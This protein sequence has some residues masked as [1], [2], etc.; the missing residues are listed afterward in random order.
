MTVL[1]NLIH[2]NAPAE[3][4]WSVLA[5]LDVL[6][7]YDPGI[8]KSEIVSPS[9]E[10]PGS[11]R[12]CDLTPG[13]WFKERVGDWN[14]QQSLSFELF[15]CSLPVRRLKHSYTLT[16]DG[17]GTLVRQ[18]MEYELKFGPIGKLM[19]AMMVRKKWDAG[20]KGFFAGLKY[21]VET[22][23]RPPGKE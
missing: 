3:K 13:G 5:S 14:P 6:D 21:Y 2:I 11:A 20:I 17:A 9:R 19:D 16:A 23:Q 18:R 22:G 12:R 8:R 1:E 7:Q 15:D 10:G 4:V